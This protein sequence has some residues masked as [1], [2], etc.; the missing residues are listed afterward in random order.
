MRIEERI[1][2]LERENRKLKVSMLSLLLLLS[3]AILLGVTTRKNSSIPEEIRAKKFILVDKE[4]RER[5]KLDI[6]YGEPDLRFFNAEGKPLMMLDPLNLSFRDAEGKIRMW[7]NPTGLS[8]AA[9][10]SEMF[11]YPWGLLLL[12]AEGKTTGLSSKDGLFLRDAVGKT[13][14]SLNPT[15]LSLGD[16]TSKRI[17]LSFKGGLFLGDAEGKTIMSLNPTGLSLR[18]AEGKTIGLS[19]KGGLSFSDAEG[20][21]RMWLKPT[22]LNFWDAGDKHRIMLVLGE[23]GPSLSLLDAEEN[24]KASIGTFKGNG[25]IDLDGYIA[26]NGYIDLNGRL[27]K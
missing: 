2:K 25:Y 4:G 18:D 19:S 12:D 27:L 6:E 17:E 5:V 14:M 13:I 16:L 1:E 8:L 20:K 10:G 26:L 15:G 11:L 23:S 22:G 9:E 7:L 24:I 3:C 21:T